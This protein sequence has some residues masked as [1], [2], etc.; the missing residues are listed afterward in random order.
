M[1]RRRRLDILGAGIDFLFKKWLGG[2]FGG[3]LAVLAKKALAKLKDEL[4][5]W[6]SEKW[7]TEDLNDYPDGDEQELLP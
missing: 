6:L 7:I 1:N 3:L 5:K 2:F 4:I